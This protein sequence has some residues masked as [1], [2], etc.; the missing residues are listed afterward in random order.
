MV[1]WFRLMMQVRVLVL[2]LVQ[3]MF[4]FSLETS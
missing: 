3:N 1:L 2:V 4:I